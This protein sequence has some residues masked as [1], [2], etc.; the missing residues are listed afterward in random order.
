MNIE[1]YTY[2][3]YDIYTNTANDKYLKN[4]VKNIQQ[5]EQLK[6]GIPQNNGEDDPSGKSNFIRVFGNEFSEYINFEKL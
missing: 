2:I 1:T 6:N 3:T 4:V 5:T